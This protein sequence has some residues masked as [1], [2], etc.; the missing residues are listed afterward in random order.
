MKKDLILLMQ[1]ESE[2]KDLSQQYL[3]VRDPCQQ[4]AMQLK[5][6]LQ[7]PKISTEAF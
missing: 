3:K 1:K 6:R 4:N 5:G 7:G 2:Q